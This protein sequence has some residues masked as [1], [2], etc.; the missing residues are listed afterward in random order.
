MTSNGTGAHTC[1]SC[2]MSVPE[3]VALITGTWSKAGG[4][5]AWECQAC[6]RAHLLDIEA[7][8]RPR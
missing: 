7:G 6:A 5:A 1:R 3:N 8:L 2:G 4:T